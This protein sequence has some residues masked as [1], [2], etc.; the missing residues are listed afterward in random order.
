M[1]S[2]TGNSPV[3]GRLGYLVPSAKRPCNYMFQPPDGVPSENCEYEDVPCAIHDARRISSAL[4][5]E[6]N[7]FELVDMPAGLSEFYDD[8]LVKEIYYPELEALA[9]RMTGGRQARVFDHLYRQRDGARPTLSFGR[10]GDGTQASAVG[11]VHNDYT[12][13]SGQRRRELVFADGSADSPFV[14]LNF[15]RPVHHA[16]IDT[17]LAVCD[18]RSFAMQDWIAGDIIYPDRTGEIYLARHSAAHRWYY[19]PSMMPSE[20][21][22]FKTYDSRLDL[23]ARM[24]AHCA[25]D[26]PTAP[27]DAPARRSIEARCLVVLD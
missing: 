20:V 19:Y 22:V 21:L 16:A 6:L 8:R 23:P 3:T 1:N 7:G 5:L 26:D 11:R 4:A 25:F 17:P 12:E 27:A 9:L 14:I 24:T 15:W 10:D 18:T 13:Q 2:D